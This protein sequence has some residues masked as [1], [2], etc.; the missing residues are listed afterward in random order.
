MA[1][2]AGASPR[3]PP[4]PQRVVEWFMVESWAEHL[5]QHRRVSQVDADLQAELRRFHVGE[6]APRVRHFLAS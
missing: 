6:E 4:T 1:P 5:R 3:T 2:M